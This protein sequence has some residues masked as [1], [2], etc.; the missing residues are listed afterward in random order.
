VTNTQFLN[1]NIF[2][3][4][5]TH[6]DEQ[7]YQACLVL[8]Q[9]AEQNQVSLVT[10]E[11]V[12]AEVVYVLSSSKHYRV[13]RPRIQVALARLLILSGLKLPQRQVCL[14]AL[15][16]YAKHS[17][18]FEDCLSLAHMEQQRI[19]QLYS[20]DLGFDRITGIHRL[21]PETITSI[22]HTFA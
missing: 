19:I 12:I 21:E 5:L 15:D 3:R 14:R 11:A 7:K 4:Y 18:D 16:L 9:Q 6:D 17:L 10:S 2:L 20:Y 22:P 13:P 1:T 8:F